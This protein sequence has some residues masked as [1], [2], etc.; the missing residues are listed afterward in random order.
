MKN[1]GFDLPLPKAR[2]SRQAK[3]EREEGV[4]VGDAVSY[5]EEANRGSIALVQATQKFALAAQAL[6][7]SGLTEDAISLLIQDLMG[8]ARN[9]K[10][11]PRETITL[12][13]RAAARL[14]EHLQEA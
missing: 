9:G 1:H 5:L 12:T 14:T 13:L 7:E 8:N 10:P 2:G 4:D 3:I 11:Y 6:L